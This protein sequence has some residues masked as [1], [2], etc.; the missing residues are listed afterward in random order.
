MEKVEREKSISTF[1]LP[2]KQKKNSTQLICFHDHPISPL[3][4]LFSEN[5]KS[6]LGA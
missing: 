5:N 1:L 3:P 6:E 4:N 2:K